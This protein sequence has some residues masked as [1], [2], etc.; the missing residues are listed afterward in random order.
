VT[1]VCKDITDTVAK[2]FVKAL[3]VRYGPSWPKELTVV[4]AQTV[5]AKDVIPAAGSLSHQD[6]EFEFDDLGVGDV[7]IVE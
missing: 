6:D 7:D 5:W 4:L 3:F 2:S 1:F